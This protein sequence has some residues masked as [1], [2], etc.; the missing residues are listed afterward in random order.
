MYHHE[1]WDG[2]GYPMG[3]SGNDIPISARIMALADVYDALTSERVYKKAFPREEA[4]SIIVSSA[5]SHFDPVL[6][7]AFEILEDKFHQLREE[8]RD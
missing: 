7:A 3:L 8:L 4:R 1:K 6:V 5:G 2:S